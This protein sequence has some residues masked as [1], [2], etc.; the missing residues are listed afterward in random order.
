MALVT[1]A[2][3]RDPASAHVARARLEAEGIPAF[4]ADDNLLQIDWV[5]SNAVGG[6]K[7]R[8]PAPY[9]DDARAA[10][11]VDASA[12]LAATDAARGPEPES[13]RCPACGSP[14]IEPLGIE[15]RSKA[16]SLMVG[17]PFGFRRGVWR[18]A[19]C[20]HRWR[21]ERAGPSLLGAAAGAVALVVDTVVSLLLGL[22]RAILFAVPG[23]FGPREFA[24]WSCGAAYGPD[25]TS[26]RQCGI[27]LPPLE[28]SQ[29]LIVPGT[30]YDTACADCHTPYRAADYDP[31]AA[32]W[33][34]SW[35]RRPLPRENAAR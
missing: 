24:C 4:V 10:L 9:A 30:E 26:C 8:V 20:D 5:M 22:R 29:E 6:V 35:C 13:A 28:A 21:P 34:C 2:T 7:L 33:F 17:V 14:A 16:L 23:V 15:R 31:D 3:F 18:C 25:D 32:E 11:A 27:P 1:V 19:T 12:E